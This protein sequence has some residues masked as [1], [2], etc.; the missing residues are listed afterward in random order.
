MGTSKDYSGSKGG[1][2]TSSKRIASQIAHDGPT[3]DRVRQYAEAYVTARGGAAAAATRS[4]AASRA[5]AGIGGFLESVRERGLTPA[6]EEL[7]LGEAIGKSA[8]EL[9]SMLVDRL[10]LDGAT[11]DDIAARDALIDCLEE[12]FEDRTYEEIGAQTLTDDS[13]RASLARFFARFVFRRCLPLLSTKLNRAT[14]D[15]RRRTEQELNDWAQAACVD[16]V[17]AVDVRTFNATGGAGVALAQE[18]VERAY[19]IFGATA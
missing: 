14:A 4:P 5:G 12:E 19:G 18:L 10:D 17:G 8:L 7:G 2:W 1:G 3:R 11:L 9:I 6:L 15:I 13:I 16:A